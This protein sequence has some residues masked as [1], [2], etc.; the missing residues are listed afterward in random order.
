MHPNARAICDWAA[1]QENP[2]KS[3]QEAGQIDPEIDAIQNQ[4]YVSLAQLVEG[5]SEKILRNCERLPCRG[6]EAWRRLTRRW[7]PMSVGRKRNML[8]NVLNPEQATMQTLS[9]A[10][11]AWKRDVG[12]YEDRSKKPLDEDIKSAVL[13]SICPKVLQT[14]LHLNQTRFI[15]YD[16][17]MDEIV[18]YLETQFGA[19]MGP[20]PM[21]I[22]SFQRHGGKGDKGKGKGKDKGSSDPGATF[23]GYCS[24]CWAW[25]HKV[26][27][28]KKG[29]GNTDD[30]KKKMACFKCGKLGH[31]SAECWSKDGGKGGKDKGKGK[32]GHKGKKG[33]HGFEGAEEEPQ[34]EEEIGGIELCTMESLDQ[35]FEE[36]L[37]NLE[38]V[39]ETDWSAMAYPKYI[40]NNRSIVSGSGDA[41]SG[42][43]GIEHGNE[44]DGGEWQQDKWARKRDRRA[45]AR[46]WKR[47]QWLGHRRIS[48]NERGQ[49]HHR[50]EINPIE[51]NLMYQPKFIDGYEEVEAAVDSGAGV[52][53]QPGEMCQSWP[54]DPAGSGVD[55]AAAG[56]QTVK[57]QGSRTFEA[58]T[59]QWQKRKVKSRVGHVR[60]MLLAACELVDKGNRI[61]LERKGSYVEHIETKQRTPLVRKNGV[62]VMKLWVKR[63]PGAPAQK[64]PEAE[65]AVPMDIGKLSKI[66]GEAQQKVD[67][68]L[69]PGEIVQASTFGWHPKV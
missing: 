57:D 28:C 9:N 11:E 23:Q 16:D 29:K 45:A 52:T 2:I 66:A 40:D 44:V 38:T 60:R 24:S 62:F 21:E 18:S 56:N 27:Q 51:L 65:A 68:G 35:I 50:H 4:L 67:Q 26:S 53:I 63:R 48:S 7:D 69:K 34:P 31:L 22:G 47:E 3:L 42:G 20:S 10:I 14:H 59:D 37:V 54:I 64:G 43:D 25:G 58:F 46:K 33:I 15:D 6:L 12:Q 39:Y 17:I 13:I 55:Y 41:I 49:Q 8:A 19:G 5:E 1:L 61:V 36:A 32:G 30:K